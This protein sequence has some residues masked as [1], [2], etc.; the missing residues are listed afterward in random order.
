MIRVILA[1]LLLVCGVQHPHAENS[2]EGRQ[3]LSGRIIRAL[4]VNARDSDHI[5]AGQKAAAAG[6]ALVFQSLDA[7]R[8]WRTLNGNRPLAP[9]ATDVQA[10]AVLSKDVL[11]AGTWKHGLFVS[12]DGGAQFERIADFPS[13]DIRD[14]QIARGKIFAATARHGIFESRDAGASWQ[15]LGPN[16]E[17]FWSV[18][19]ASGRLFAGSLESGVH[20]R[21]YG[22]WTHHFSEDNIYAIAAAR[23][24]SAFRVLAG[25]QGLYFSAGPDWRQVLAGEKFAD[26]A[27]AGRDLVLAASWTDGVV[28]L[29]R[30]GVVQ[31]R[32]LPGVPV[33]HLQS[34][35]GTLFA[36]TWGQGLH[37]IPMGMASE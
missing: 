3:V 11:L 20:M 10:V 22:K 33:V 26:A 24:P 18:T 36:G 5:L 13:N 34:A 9:E 6:S 16:S 21:D 23:R 15:V 8:T 30:D 19:V 17:F 25:E 31:E 7:G 2:G 37:I 29:N 14:L 4:A 27:I 35:G 28:V 12:R 32:L 1:L